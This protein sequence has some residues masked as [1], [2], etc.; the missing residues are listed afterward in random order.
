M[1]DL[2]KEIGNLGRAFEEFKNKNDERIAQIEAKGTADPLV[3]EQV[4]K[5]NKDMTDIQARIDELEAGLTRP[6][7]PANDED[8]AEKA[9]YREAFASWMRS[10][11][12][13]EASNRLQQAARAAGIKAEVKTT[14]NGDGGYAVPE[15]IASEIEKKLIDVSPMRQIARVVQVGTS[16]YKE[17]VDVRGTASGWVGETGTRSETGTSSLEEVAPTFGTV[18]AYPKATEESLDDMFFNVE[19]WLTDS[20]LEE[21]AYQEGLAF[22]DGNGTNKPTG[23]LAGTPESAGDE[24]SPARTFGELQYLPT[25]VSDGFGH[26]PNGSPEVFGGDTLISTVYALKA[27]YRANA[28]WTMNKS[29]LETARKW[30]DKDG[31]YIWQPGLQMGQPSSLMGY[32]VVEMEGMADIGANAFPMAFGD[33]SGYLITDR[34]GIRITVDPYTT[35]GY[36]KFYVRKRVGGKL[37]NDDKIKVIKCSTS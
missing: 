27:G 18:Y 20:V 7:R 19:Q 8:T 29:T 1:A 4:E 11:K 14:A 28:R 25:G 34:V 26:D 23:F 5:A 9:E 32:P 35:P 15:V 30:K 22:I 13:V 21:F 3:V 16:D 12:D 31:Q 33:F 10:P 17:L 6:S 37:K 36:I 24:D 2:A